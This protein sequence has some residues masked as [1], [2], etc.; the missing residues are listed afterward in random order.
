MTRATVTIPAADGARNVLVF[1]HLI[2]AIVQT[3]DGTCIIHEGGRRHEVC[4]DLIAAAVLI[5]THPGDAH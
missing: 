4:I 3:D 5:A 2:T 1:P